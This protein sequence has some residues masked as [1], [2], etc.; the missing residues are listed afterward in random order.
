MAMRLNSARTRN[1]PILHRNAVTAADKL[2]VPGA[3]VLTDVNESGSTLAH[4]AMNVAVSAYNRWGSTNNTNLATLT[5]TLDHAINVAFSQVVGADGYDLFLSTDAAPLW[6]ARIT[7]AERAAG[8]FIISAVGTVTAGGSAPAGSVDIGIVGTGVANNATPF[9]GEH[10][11]MLTCCPMSR[12]SAATNL[13][14]RIFW[15]G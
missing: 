11:A 8:G 3:L 15:L 10:E 4:S 2:A 13:K 9:L 1:P 14:S 12:R 5:P 6:V 7:E